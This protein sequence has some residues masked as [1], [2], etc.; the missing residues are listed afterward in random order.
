MS[1][2]VV[3]YLTEYPEIQML[4]KKYDPT[5][6]MIGPHITLVFPF[7]DVQRDKIVEH[8]S[9]I[10]KISKPF[11]FRLHGLRKSNDNWLFLTV[12]EGRDKIIKLHDKLYTS[13]LKKH[14]RAGFIPHVGIGKFDSNKKYRIAFDEA[15]N[16]NLDYRCKATCMHLIHLNDH[17]KI[18][19]TER[20]ELL[21]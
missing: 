2:A 13:F 7:P 21:G 6:D 9:S 4:R 5:F 18:D 3:I 11:D 12:D 1:Y 20:Y 15:K 19:W 10:A 17:D 14:L 16:L 8:V